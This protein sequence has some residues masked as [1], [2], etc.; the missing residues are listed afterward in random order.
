MP[1][2]WVKAF[3]NVKYFLKCFQQLNFMWF[4]LF[5]GLNELCKSCKLACKCWLCEPCFSL[6]LLCENFPTET[7]FSPE[8]EKKPRWGL[9]LE[10]A[11]FVFAFR[12]I[13][14]PSKQLFFCS[15]CLSWPQQDPSAAG[16]EWLHQR[17]PHQC[18]GGAEKLHSHSGKTRTTLR[19]RVGDEQLKTA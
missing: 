14:T 7:F 10:P 18:R 1:N 2:G 5:F 16:Y 12:S 17:Q 6:T 9:C 8:V 11:L 19:P 4:P 13:F 15:F 3:W